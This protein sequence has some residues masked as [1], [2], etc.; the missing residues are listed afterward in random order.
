MKKEDVIPTFSEES[1]QFQKMHFTN[2]SRRH[3]GN[4]GHFSI[5]ELSAFTSTLNVRIS[6]VRTHQADQRFNLRDILVPRDIEFYGILGR[7][8]T[9]PGTL[10]VYHISVNQ[11]I[12]P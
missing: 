12:E 5:V 7:H 11:T 6:L 3:E 9:T 2:W 8:E 10:Y 4:S 1:R